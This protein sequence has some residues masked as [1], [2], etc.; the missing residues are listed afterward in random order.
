MDRAVIRVD[1]AVSNPY[2]GTVKT[3]KTLEKLTAYVAGERLLGAIKLS[4]NENPR[5]SAPRAVE[6]IRA[7]VEELR[8]YPDGGARDLKTAIA[9]H[10]DSTTDRIVLGNG[11]DELLTMIAAAYLDPGSRVL[12]GEHTFSQYAF[13]AR[14]FDAEVAAVPMPALAFDL[15]L[16]LDSLDEKTRIVYLCSPNNPTGLTI[17]QVEFDAFLE[18]VGD[19]RLVVVDHAYQDYVDDTAALAADRYVARGEPRQNLIVLHTFSK[20]Y[21]LAALRVGY[22]LAAPERIAELE[23]VRS[24]FNINTLAQVAAAAALTDTTFAA[25]SIETNRLG[26]LRLYAIFDDLGLPYL[27]TQANFVTVQVPEEARIVGDKIAKRGVTVRALTSFGLPYHLRITVGTPEQI[28]SLES[29]LREL[30][31]R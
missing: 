25:E 21:G 31:G 6:A 1:R 13:S 30:L 11:S 3:R 19:D 15:N 12:I 27:P 16:V 18:R 4:S 5:G 9:R 23:K 7:A 22:A 26:K 2:Y 17:P 24:P 29:I 20:L 28:D 8:Y 14:L 10:H